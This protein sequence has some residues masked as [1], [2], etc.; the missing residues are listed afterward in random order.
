M[1][2]K[3]YLSGILN[4]NRQSMSLDFSP[5]PNK[6][7]KLPQVVSQG[8]ADWDKN[9]KYN[10]YVDALQG[11][12]E[13]AINEAFAAYDPQGYANYMQDKAKRA[14][15]RQWKLDDLA[16]QRA[17]QEKMQQQAFNN[18]WGLAKWRAEHEGT[19]K[20]TAQQNIEYLSSNLGI[21]LEQAAQ[22]VYSGQNPTLNMAS[23]GQKGSEA[24][25]KSRGEK[26]AEDVDAYNNLVANLPALEQMTQELK[27]LG[28]QGTHTYAGRVWDAIQREGFD[29]ATAGDVASSA[30]QAKVNQNLLP[31]LRTTFGASFTEKDREAMEKTLGDPFTHPDIKD[32]TLDEF[33]KNKRREIESKARKLQSYSPQGLQQFNPAN[34]PLSLR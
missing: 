5:I 3:D 30:Y 2:N 32:K 25:D 28:K 22:L 24:L 26:Y 20:T 33:I 34:D 6:W 16:E 7:D 14:E 8:I 11:G 19:P 9:Q 13:N 12:D 31:L 21:P 1:L 17:F 10:A 23:F 29:K 27:D 18:Q 4:A 15:E